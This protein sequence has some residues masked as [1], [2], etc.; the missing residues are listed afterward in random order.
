MTDIAAA[1]ATEAEPA[2]AYAPPAERIATLDIVRGV[3]VMGIL[4]MNIVAFAMPFQAYMNPTAFGLESGA[5]L[6]SWLVS[7]I[8][9]DGKMRGLFSFLFGASTLLVIERAKASGLSPARV[10]YA[11]MFW[12]LVFGLLHF[13]FIWFGDILAAYALVGLVLFLFRNLS[14]R[15]LV[16]WGIVFVVIQC[17]LFGALGAG[18]LYLSHAAAQPGAAPDIVEGWRSMQEGFTTLTGPDLA[19][20]LAHFQGPYSGLVHQRLVEDWRA[21]FTGVLFFGWETLGYMLL[22]MAA[23]KSGFFRGEWPLARYRKVALIGFGIGV[24]AY[25]VLAWLLV[26]SNFSVEMIFAIVMGATTP[27]RPFMILAIAALIV[28]LT[29][30]GGALVDRIAAAGRAAFTN[31]LGTSILMTTLFYGY[32]FG[33]FGTMSRVQLWLPVLAMWALMLLWSKPWLDRFRYG[34][35]EW[36]WRSL[37][38]HRIE[39]MRK[40]S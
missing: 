40:G 8:F 11:R 16:T 25:A 4:A 1:D 38:R 13:Y 24:P 29:R 33:L 27:F 19:A 26:G 23:L 9:I 20:K 32:G 39:P 12:L 35:F 3:A 22:G 10:H 6:G 14:V 30:K 36:L 2:E 21:P 28:I 31:Y 15:G 5:D 37:A 18:A 7:F 34:P 17:L